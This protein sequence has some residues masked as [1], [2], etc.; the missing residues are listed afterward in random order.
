ME[1]KNEGFELFQDMLGGVKRNVVTTLLK[2]R[3]EDLAMF[4]AI[5]FDQPLQMF[6]YTSGDDLAY[7]TS[8]SDA[9]QSFGPEA[10]GP[11]P[12]ETPAGGAPAVEAGSGASGSRRP[13]PQAAAWPCSSASWSRRLAATTR[14]GAGAGRSTRSVTALEPDAGARVASAA[15]A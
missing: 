3:P 13:R 8:F 12:F 10:A 5:T 7:Q 9:A 11:G 1:Y 4:T 15:L 14:A 2:N 6:N